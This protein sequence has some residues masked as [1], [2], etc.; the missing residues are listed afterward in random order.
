MF[1][2]NSYIRKYYNILSTSPLNL[3]RPAIAHA[4]IALCI[5]VNQMSTPRVSLSIVLLRT[6]NV[7]YVIHDELKSRYV[8][9]QGTHSQATDLKNTVI[10]CNLGTYGS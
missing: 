8:I 4:P 1:A 5:Y 9:F 3:L 6:I 10:G 7:V 2:V